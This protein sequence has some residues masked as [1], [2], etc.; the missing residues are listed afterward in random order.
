MQTV[1]IIN[2][3][4]LGLL[5][6]HRYIFSFLGSLF[7]GGVIMILAGV[8]LK[9][10][11]FKFWGLIAI[12]ISGYFLNGIG[13]YLIGRIGGHRVLQRLAKHTRP[14]KSL[15]EKLEKY[16]QKHSV[17]TIFL[18]RITYG[19]S[20]PAFITAGSAKMNLKKFLITSFVGAVIWVLMLLVIGIIFGIGFNALKVVVRAITFGLGALIFAG[21]IIVSFILIFWI[22]KF[23]ETEFVK[24]L[25]VHEESKIL[26]WIGSAIKK[27]AR[28]KDI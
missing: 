19:L 16:Y 18:A 22:R 2:N 7:E 26:R 6:E 12:L 9:L 15:L 14:G 21:I 24:E 25:S 13:F 4:V 1:E 23:A 27:L 20:V 3:S 5:Y 10:G 8:L 28:S 11:Y 17:K